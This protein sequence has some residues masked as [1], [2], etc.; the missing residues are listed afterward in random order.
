MKEQNKYMYEDEPEAKSRSQ[1][2]RESTAMQ[3]MGEDLTKLSASALKALG[4]PPLLVEAVREYRSMT[5]HE[6]RRRQMQYIGRMMREVEDPEG[7]AERLTALGEGKQAESE[8]F[9]HLEQMRERLMND[10]ADAVPELLE[11]FPDIDVQHLR[12]LVR[13]AKKEREKA[14]APKSFRALFRYLRDMEESAK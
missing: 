6:S 10:D 5:T 8:A 7:L 14:K 12:Q 3:R 9:H 1:K 2:K 13:N 4:L 11:K